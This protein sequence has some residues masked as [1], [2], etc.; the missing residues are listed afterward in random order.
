[1]LYDCDLVSGK[2]YQSHNC[3]NY[4]G[5]ESDELQ[6]PNF[7]DEKIHPEDIKDFQNKFDE[8]FNDPE[9]IFYHYKYRFKRADGSYAFLIDKGRILRDNKGIG[10]RLV[11]ITSDISKS[12]EALRQTISS[13]K[14]VLRATNAIY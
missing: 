5:Y 1:M 14:L 2:I 12:E 11:G 6:Q 10:I 4:L 7:W 13:F 9:K 3:D 8:K